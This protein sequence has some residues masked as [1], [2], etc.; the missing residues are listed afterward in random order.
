MILATRQGNAELRRGGEYGS[1][2]I[3]VPGSRAV[4]FS[5]RAVTPSTASAL[6]AVGAAIR[7]VSEIVA[8]LPM[9]VYQRDGDRRERAVSSPQWALL[10][11]QP[12]SEQS[13]Y[14]FFSDVAASI[15]ACGNAVIQKIKS[16]GRVVE[17]ILVDPDMVQIRRDRNTQQKVFDIRVD[18]KTYRDLTTADIL[19]VR[20]F[21]LQGGIIGLSP[22]QAHRNALGNAMALEEYQG[23]FFRNDATPGLVIK[24][25]GQISA[26]QAKQI[27]SV[28]ADTH[29]GLGNAHRPAVLAGGAELQRIPAMD[30]EWVATSKLGIEDVARIY[31]LP[32][33]TLA[34]EEGSSSQ[35]SEQ[36]SLRFLLY[37]L[38]P[39]LRRIEMAFRADSDLF[40]SG[41][42]LFCEFLADSLLRADTP[43]RYAAYVAGRQAGWITPNEIRAREGLPPISDAQADQI[44][45]T[46][47]GGAPNPSA[48]EAP[49][50]DPS[51]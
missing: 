31:R 48:S 18:G 37:S 2:A 11:D 12:N 28:W 49:T 23:R 19:H 22:I 26:T 40:G 38:A 21:T 50:P 27:L 45:L 39:R 3:P 24:T 42:N 47:V 16:K 35:S 36:E 17:L 9:I 10:H 1:S 20:G 8:S 5:G 41:S 14:D 34:A 30:S 32:K 6:P 25:P 7:T 15:E 4:A 43:T 46:P 33:W 51:A 13:P 44:Q 29:G